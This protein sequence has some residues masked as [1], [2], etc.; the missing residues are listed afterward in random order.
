MRDLQPYISEILPEIIELRHSIHRYP[1]PGYQE[2]ETAK[3][4]V[5]ALASIDGLEVQRSGIAET[6]IV[7]LLHGEALGPCVALRAE[8]DCLPI[9]EQSG[10]PYSSER[11]GF[12]HACG[13]DGHTACVVGA[14]KVLGRI[15]DELSGP[16]KFIFQPAEEGGAGAERMCDAGGLAEP[17][18]DALFAL[19]GWPWLAQGQVSTTKGPMLAGSHRFEIFIEGKGGHAAKPQS[20]I[21]PVVVA[22]HLVIALQTVVSRNL[23]PTKAVVLTIGAL[24]CGD[25]HNVI[26]DSATMSGTLRFFC[27]ETAELVRQRMQEIAAH[28]AQAFGASARIEFGVMYPPLSNEPRATE[29]VMQIADKVIDSISLKESPFPAMFSEDFSFYGRHLATCFWALGVRPPDT[30]E[31]AKL[32]QPSYDFPDEA[33]PQAIEMHCEIVRR[34]TAPQ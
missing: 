32:H 22:S 10:K 16:V 30:A 34:W 4:V 31:Y 8:M 33:I 11:P 18:V 27:M 2:Y 23:S 28:T 26:A 19:H 5:S 13:H 7:A 21:D 14:A 17:D 20:T 1:E 25:A 24:K 9:E 6:G 29:H 12:M 15:R 3:K